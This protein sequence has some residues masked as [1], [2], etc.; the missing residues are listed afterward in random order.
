MSEK[1]TWKEMNEKYP[2]RWLILR[3]TVRERG[4]D[5]FEG[6]VIGVY[7]DDEIEDVIVN[8]IS[9]KQR[10]D[11]VRTTPGNFPGAVFYGY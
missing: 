1:L 8:L 10:F 9:S 6:T 11:K 7:T 5:I 3:D 4:A 2:D